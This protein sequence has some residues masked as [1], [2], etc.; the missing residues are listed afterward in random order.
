[1]MTIL[2]RC[3]DVT[4]FFTLRNL[5]SNS[6]VFLQLLF[7]QHLFQFR[8]QGF[9]LLCL[10]K[11]EALL[12]W[13]KHLD[14]LRV[15]FFEGVCRLYL[16]KDVLCCLYSQVNWLVWGWLSWQMNE[17]ILVRNVSLFGFPLIL[18]H[19]I[20]ILLLQLKQRHTIWVPWGGSLDVGLHELWRL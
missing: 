3:L 18:H 20:V 13:Q 19:F 9:P 16:F 2:Q 15:R 7:F 5:L 12:V 8:A 10:S 1:L 14:E 11:V 4:N 17:F 6:Y